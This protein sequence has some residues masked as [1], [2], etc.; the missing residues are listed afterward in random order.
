MPAGDS[1]TT[2]SGH[3]ACLPQPSSQAGSPLSAGTTW[4]LLSS[5]VD[6]WLQGGRSPAE[7]AAQCPEVAE[8]GQ[9]GSL[10]VGAAALELS[11]WTE[12]ARQAPS[13]SLRLGASVQ[14]RPLSKE[15][16]GR[17]PRVP[18]AADHRTPWLLSSDVLPTGQRHVYLPSDSQ[19]R[20]LRRVKT[21][22]PRRSA[23]KGWVPGGSSEDPAPDLASFSHRTS[24]HLPRGTRAFVSF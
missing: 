5:A 24:H 20:E 10:R 1:F 6:V 7:Q 19:H 9:G 13:C 8:W 22:A 21:G 11:L 23:L 2:V 12:R 3:R 15:S 4:A 17:V 16:A 18:G 14:G